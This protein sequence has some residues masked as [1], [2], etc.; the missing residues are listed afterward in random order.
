MYRQELLRARHF[1]PDLQTVTSQ[2][3]IRRLE[4]DVAQ[5]GFH[6]PKVGLC[7]EAC[8]IEDGRP[9][10]LEPTLQLIASLPRAGYELTRCGSFA[11]VVRRYHYSGMQKS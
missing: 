1:G 5:C 2:E 3:V 9:L 4:L 10:T 11:M 8:S 7:A 6:R